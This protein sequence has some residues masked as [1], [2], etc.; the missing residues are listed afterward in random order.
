MPLTGPGFPGQR[1]HGSRT[2]ARSARLRLLPL[3]QA[4]FADHAAFR[5]QPVIE[6]PAERGPRA[7]NRAQAGYSGTGGNFQ[8]N[9]PTAMTASVRFVTFRALR[10]A[11]MWCFTV[12]S[13]TSRIRE[14]VLL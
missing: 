5:G 11:V 3:A 7:H 4:G 13:A 2:P 8:P 10:I 1:R 6:G 12:G 14:I 9:A